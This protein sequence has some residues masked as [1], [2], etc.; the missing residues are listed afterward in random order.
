MN[1][2]CIV[3]AYGLVEDLLRLFERGNAPNIMWHLFLHSTIPQVVTACDQ[4]TAQYPNLYY[5]RHMRNRGLSASWNDGIEAAYR[6]GADVALII[7]DDMIP[8]PGDIQKV[9]Q[10]ALDHPDCGIVKCWGFD[11]RSMTHTTMEFGLTAITKRGWEV[12]GAF[13][14]NIFPIYWEDIDWGRRHGLA[15]LPMHIVDNTSAVHAGS[16]TSVTVPGLLQETSQAY[17]QNEAYYRRKWGRTHTEGESYATPFN[18]P[19][20]TFYI[21][22]E[23][24]HAP[25]PGYD[26]TDR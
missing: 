16:K 7:N 8:G 20:L 14:E 13:D 9:A 18:D 4:L 11:L 23:Q 22:P 25:Y 2:H 26:R 6:D 17:N 1:I 19:A 21:A 24:R 12:V 15:G 3:I 10:A 5:Y